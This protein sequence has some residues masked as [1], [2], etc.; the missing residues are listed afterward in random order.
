[1]TF[2]LL[3]T[4]GHSNRS[5]ED[6]LAILKAH[7]IERV[8][9]VRRFPASR[10]WPHFNAGRNM[11]TRARRGTGISDE[12]FLI[13]CDAQTSGGLLVALPADQAEAYAARAR[14]LGA[15]AA[16]V[17]GTVQPSSAAP[18]EVV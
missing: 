15:P 4:V 1:M 9:D 18:V 3:F 17:V 12:D 10:K 5:F 16:A 8:I 13:V 14:E 7:R 2:H 6:F 11:N